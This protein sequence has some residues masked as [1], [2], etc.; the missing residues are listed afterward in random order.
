DTVAFISEVDGS[1]RV[2]INRT[3]VTGGT[4]PLDLVGVADDGVI[5]AANLSA[6]S[7]S[8]LII[9]RWN[10][11]ADG[12]INPPITAFTASPAPTPRYGDSMDI[13]G[14][15]TNTQIIMSGSSSSEFGVFT[16]TDGTNFTLTQIPLSGAGLA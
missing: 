13:R 14:A 16:T 10:S 3:G 11:E 5:Y 4:L 15:G 1:E 6:A 8:T 9:Y 7:S 12:M 2:S